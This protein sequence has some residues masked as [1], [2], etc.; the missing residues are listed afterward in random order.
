MPPQVKFDKHEILSAA[1]D[2]ARKKGIE[3]ITARELAKAL[4]CSTKPI[5][6]AFR[7]MDELI[8]LL[9]DEIGKY[10]A[11]YVLQKSQEYQE[12]TLI[13]RIGMAYIDFAL[14]ESEFFRI[15]FFS[16]YGRQIDTWGMLESWL[17]SNT[18]RGSTAFSDSLWRLSTQD[19]QKINR[20]FWHYVHGIACH[21]SNDG[22][23]AIQD[24]LSMS[25]NDVFVAMM[26]FYSDQPT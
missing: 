18:P 3:A 24:S 16:H 1:F 26:R 2:T 11:D 19:R 25:L 14:N 12:Y 22:K 9:I 7:N 23:N 15:L 17:L 4:S 5:F 20:S 10:F 8:E 13:I 6:S 21:A